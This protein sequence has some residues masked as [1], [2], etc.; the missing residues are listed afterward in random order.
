[1]IKTYDVVDNSKFQVDIA[2][3]L[4][5]V[6]MMDTLLLHNM[7]VRLDSDLSPVPP[8]EPGVNITEHISNSTDLYQTF[9]TLYGG[10]PAMLIIPHILRWAI[11]SICLDQTDTE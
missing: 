11:L 3:R 9:S 6:F 7:G 8:L 10:N 4:P 2:M 1:M 5:P